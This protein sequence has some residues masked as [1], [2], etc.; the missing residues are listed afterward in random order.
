VVPLDERALQRRAAQIEVPLLEADLLAGLD[1]V[2]DLERGGLGLVEH[3]GLEHQHLDLTGRDFRVLVGAAREHEP[4]HADDPL[5]S[6]LLGELVRGGDLLG[7]AVLRGA[8]VLRGVVAI[9]D[10]LRDPGAVTQ[11]DEDAAAMI[12]PGRDPAE[13]DHDVPLV[14]GPQVATAVGAL[15]L[16]DESAHISSKTRARERAN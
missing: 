15:Q 6:H 9:E 10:D 1:V 11:V 3:R 14:R 16:V 2:G 5:P 13:E 4:A 8:G 12:A 7:G